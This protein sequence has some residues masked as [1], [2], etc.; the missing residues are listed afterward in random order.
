MIFVLGQGFFV[1]HNAKHG[2]V[3][4]IRRY[5]Q[6]SKFPSVGGAYDR[7]KLHVK[8]FCY[9]T[10]ENRRGALRVENH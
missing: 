10:C 5:L 9:K 4:C 1:I 6:V 8:F 7:V 2:R 3:Y